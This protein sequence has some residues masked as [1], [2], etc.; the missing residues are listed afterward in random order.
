MQPRTSTCHY[1]HQTTR[2]SLPIHAVQNDLFSVL[3][4][5]LAGHIFPLQAHRFTGN[6]LCKGCTSACGTGK[7]G[8]RHQCRFRKKGKKKR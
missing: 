3:R 8:N 1:R 2:Q 4:R 6:R 7:Q 5:D